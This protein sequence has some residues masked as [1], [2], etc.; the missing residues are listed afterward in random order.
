MNSQE[1]QVAV[2]WG[3]GGLGTA[4]SEALA[5]D[6]QYDQVVL[7]SRRPEVEAS[8]Y[9]KVITADMLDENSIA[10]AVKSIRE[11]GKISLV[12]VATGLLHDQ[13]LQPEKSLKQ[14]DRPSIETV[15]AVNTVGP[16]LLA[17]HFLPHMPRKERAVFAAISARV[18]SISDNRLGGWFS[19]RASK[20]ALNMMLKTL[21][22]EWSRSNSQSVCI[23]LH[24]GTVD[25]ALSKPFQR[26][27]S[28]NKL[29]SA[30]H[31]AEQLIKVLQEANNE[32]TGSVFDYAGNRVPE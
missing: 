20:A 19:Y 26:G 8:S 13:T 18:G 14:L 23:G 11:L 15:L 4:L 16:T 3:A 7:V 32:H 2:V 10:S 5:S 27:V 12:I 29:F 31:S 9:I 21:A 17:K 6:K 22:I 24:P 28:A 25:T 1:N 30:K